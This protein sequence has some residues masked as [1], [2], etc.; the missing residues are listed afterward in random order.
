M[1]FRIAAEQPLSDEEAAALW[2]LR[3]AVKQLRY[4]IEKEALSWWRTPTTAHKPGYDAYR[5]FKSLSSFL[6]RVLVDSGENQR[7]P[8]RRDS[9]D[10]HLEITGNLDDL[11]YVKHLR[12]SDMASY[13][14]LVAGASKDPWVQL[15]NRLEESRLAEQQGQ[16]AW[17]SKVASTIVVRAERISS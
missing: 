14:E 15:Y 10:R 3:T 12:D 11:T 4:A 17:A 5:T 1:L 16:A 7:P 13:Q 9:R 2:C 8:S 6:A